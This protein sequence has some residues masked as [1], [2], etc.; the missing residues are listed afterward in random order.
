MVSDL[1]MSLQVTVEMLLH[2]EP[3]QQ[4][5][6]LPILHLGNRTPNLLNLGFYGIR[7]IDIHSRCD[8]CSNKLPST[9]GP[10]TQ[11]R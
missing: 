10:G 1:E 5:N 3:N 4:K 6:E 8:D 2:I 11:T 9:W 7:I